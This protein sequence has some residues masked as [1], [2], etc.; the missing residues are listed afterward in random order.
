MESDLVV[1]V[2]QLKHDARLLTDNLDD[3]A[4][5]LMD[6]RLQS[7]LKDLE[8]EK[9]KAEIERLN[10]LMLKEC[11]QKQGATPINPWESYD[12]H[13]KQRRSKNNV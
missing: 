6:L 9:L 13:Q 8:I 2:K 1:T 11:L 4:D 7:Q 12:S 10:H 3:F 5:R